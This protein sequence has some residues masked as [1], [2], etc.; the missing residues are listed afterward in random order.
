MSVRISKMYGESADG[1]FWHVWE[2]GQKAE[3]GLFVEGGG[4]SVDGPGADYPDVEIEAWS[5]EK[6]ANF[7]IFL[8]QSVCEAIAKHVE[9]LKH[10]SAT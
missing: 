7:T 6:G 1:R 8:P 5:E 10:R 2:H 9:E 4:S 3:P